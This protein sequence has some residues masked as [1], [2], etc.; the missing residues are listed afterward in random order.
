MRG[1]GS[2]PRHTASDSRR[3]KVLTRTITL[4]TSIP[5]LPPESKTLKML[6]FRRT[7]VE[8]RF[9]FR[10]NADRQFPERE[11]T[12]NRLAIKL[13]SFSLLLLL[14]ATSSAAQEARHHGATKHGAEHEAKGH[15]FGVKEFDLFHDVLHPLQHEA[16]PNNDFQTI[17]ARAN[18]LIAAGRAITRL[19]TPKRMHK[20]APYRKEMRTFRAALTRFGKDAS[21][22]T[23]AQLTQSYT[24]VHDSF[25]RLAV[26][27]PR[28]AKH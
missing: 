19:S 3:P 12:M 14:S 22:G 1:N 11:I 15:S 20:P 2:A 4:G 7:P 17:R 25:E 13:L 6:L 18:E 23:D 24:A 8:R 16:L 10:H 28:K 21:A 9:G 26:M 27:L 5:C